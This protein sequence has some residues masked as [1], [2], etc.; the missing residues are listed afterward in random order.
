[1]SDKESPEMKA[2][3]ARRRAA[4]KEK[5]RARYAKWSWQFV[6]AE[7]FLLAL[8]PPAA[9]VALIFAVILTILR[10]RADKEF[11]FRQLP[12][13]VPLGLFVLLSALSI[14]V[15]PDRAFSFYNWYNLVGVYVL[16]YF[17]VGQNL[18][19]RQQ[20]KEL[21]VVMGAAAVL[22]LLYGF[23]Q[24][25]FGIDISAMKWVDGDAFPELRK[26]VFSTWENPNIL[27]GYLDI[28]ICLAFGLF[29]KAGTKQK[30]I[31][32]GAL[33]AASAACLA[34]TYARG[35]CLVIAAIFVVYGML[36]DW[37][38]LLVCAV[39]GIGLL[40]A[41]PV[42]YERLTSVF[43]KVDTSSEMRLA[44]WESTIAMI[45]DHPFL[46]IGW[47]AYWKV[48]PEY[49]FYLQG[50]DVLI[51]HAHNMYLNY[52]A[53]IGI[54]GMLSFMW[55]F[56]GS[57]W[58]AL[59]QRF[60]P[61]EPVVSAPTPFDY[62]EEGTVD[63]ELKKISDSVQQPE[64]AP[65]PSLWQDFLHWEDW[66]LFSG[67]SL[68]LGLALISV[69][70]NGITDDLLFNIPSSMFLWMLMAFIAALAAFNPP[71][72]EETEE[73]PEVVAE[74]K[75]SGEEIAAEPTLAEKMKAD[76]EEEQQA[77]EN[78][79]AEEPAEAG[80]AAQEVAKETEQE[81]MEE[82][83]AEVE[84]DTEAINDQEEKAKDDNKDEKE[85]EVH[86]KSGEHIKGDH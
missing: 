41:D 85:A 5:W 8:L 27:A 20:V 12:F 29:I 48:Y 60:L 69:A 23:Y 75:V 47:G 81:V 24:F 78:T 16:T 6:L 86:E 43:T 72:D 19:S 55:L 18:R 39:V 38:V 56:F 79:E 9:T 14:L 11:T 71:K 34:M 28:I 25:L 59:Q 58:L 37:R 68:G 31:V 2:V 84:A 83:E 42:L 67:A 26:R 80:E 3:N 57:L 54:P 17:V 21:L 35:A 61:A 1:M 22:V 36:K 82:A 50:A 45:Q 40:L 33:L 49:D 70:L 53:E 15:S 76:M 51:V 74:E 77:A 44:F 73:V 66:R 64:T 62:N 7:A 52:A 13:D 65:Q 63:A 10:F 4:N 46:G 32:L 30:R